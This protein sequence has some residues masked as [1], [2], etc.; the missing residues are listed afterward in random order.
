[1]ARIPSKHITRDDSEKLKDL[2]KSEKI[3]IWPRL[4]IE[5]LCSIRLSR[6]GLKRFKNQ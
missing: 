4:S 2:D 1:M 5:K 3:H 6:A